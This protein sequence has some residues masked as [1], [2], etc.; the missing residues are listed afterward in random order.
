MASG[1]SGKDS[2]RDYP[3]RCWGS[4]RTTREGADGRRSGR[5]RP[6]GRRSRRRKW[7]YPGTKGKRKV[8]GTVRGFFKHSIICFVKL[9]VFDTENFIFLLLKT[10]V[11]WSDQDIHVETFSNPIK[12]YKYPTSQ[13]VWTEPES[14]MTR[15]M[16]PSTSS[17]PIKHTTTT[18]CKFIAWEIGVC[19][20]QFFAPFLSNTF[21]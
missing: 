21:F 9:F 8:P 18:S 13:T 1:Q 17:L 5:R 4:P 7:T 15:W 11:S 14:D 16:C 3:R 10:F 19:F 6:S 2:N 12:I 20:W